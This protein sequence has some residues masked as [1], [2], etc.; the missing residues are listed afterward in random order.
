MFRTAQFYSQVFALAFGV[1]QKGDF[2]PPLE[3]YHNSLLLVVLL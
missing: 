1:I 3:V 2:F